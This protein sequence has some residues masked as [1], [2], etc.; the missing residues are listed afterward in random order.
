[1]STKFSLTGWCGTKCLL[2]SSCPILVQRCQCS[3]IS[4]GVPTRA[5]LSHLMLAGSRGAAG[6]R[7][8][9]TVLTTS[10][11]Y[12][13]HMGHSRVAWTGEPCTVH[14]VTQAQARQQSRCALLG[15]AATC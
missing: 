10:E 1:M 14:H 9:V 11:A 4:R 2:D 13:V 8:L 3:L 5:L 6:S 7:V 12:I 15:S